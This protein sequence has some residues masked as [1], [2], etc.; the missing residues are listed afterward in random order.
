MTH[1]YQQN[2]TQLSSSV[3][4]HLKRISKP[5]LILMRYRL[6]PRVNQNISRSYLSVSLIRKYIFTA[7][8]ILLGQKEGLDAVIL[9]LI[10][11]IAYITYLLLVRPFRSSTDNIIE[12]FLEWMYLIILTLI[13][14]KTPN[15]EP[16]LPYIILTICI[17]KLS[18]LSSLFYRFLIHFAY[19][20]WLFYNKIFYRFTNI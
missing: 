9:L 4:S 17:S 2:I 10:L 14:A 15:W 20:L 7:L 12:I 19:I 13:V 1:H 16:I 8:V 18:I 5:K 11:Q 3:V 6:W